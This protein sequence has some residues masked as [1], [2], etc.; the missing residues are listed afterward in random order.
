M[1]TSMNLAPTL[2]ST[3]LPASAGDSTSR[4][5]VQGLVAAIVLVAFSAFSLWVVAQH[6]YFGFFT[7][8]GR[9]PWAM[10]MLIDLVISCSFGIA[11]MTADA[12]KHGINR[13]PFVVATILLGSIGILDY[14][15]WRA[16][17]PR[18]GT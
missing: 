14:V 1:K 15:V 10:Q 16:I 17:R 12:R 6:G 13:W 3:A 18:Q 2:A 7:L 8:A 5:R 9:E 11:W 4:I